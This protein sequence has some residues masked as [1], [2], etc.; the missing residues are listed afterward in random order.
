VVPSC[1]SGG[2][3]G[4]GGIG[5]MVLL[6]SGGGGGGHTSDPVMGDY[7]SGSLASDLGARVPVGHPC[8]PTQILA[9]R[10]G[11]DLS[12]ESSTGMI[13]TRSSPSSSSAMMTPSPPS[14]GLGDESSVLLVATGKGHE[15][16]PWMVQGALS[17]LSK[18]WPG[19]RIPSANTPMGQGREMIISQED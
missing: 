5:V 8:A 19:L 3:G 16:Q 15:S 13:S 4:G 11:A 7:P 6:D 9:V 17:D 2:G 18:R 14:L 12:G 10:L 1:C